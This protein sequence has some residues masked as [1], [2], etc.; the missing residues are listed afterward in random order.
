MA[1]A[2]NMPL[3]NEFA[4][5]PIVVFYSNPVSTN[6]LRLDKEH[7][8]V[9]EMLKR[10]GRPLE[11]VLRKHATTINDMLHTLK[12]QPFEIIL[13]SGHGD[14]AGILIEPE[15]GNSSVILEPDRLKNLIASSGRRPRAI[16]LLACYSADI[17]EDLLELSQFVITV[18]GPADDAAAIEF[19][20]A[21]MEDYLAH[22][23]IETAFG[24]AQKTIFAKGLTLSPLLSRHGQ[25]KGRAVYA[26][27]PGTFE[28]SILVDISDI[29][30]DIKNLG[31]SRDS[32]LRMLTQ[33]IRVH[34][35]LFKVAKE[36]AIIPIGTCFGVF[37]WTAPAEIVTCNRLL[38]V[39]EDAPLDA[40][41]AWTSALIAYNDLFVHRYRCVSGPVNP[42]GYT[43]ILERAVKAYYA[44]FKSYLADS[45]VNA[46]IFQ[47]LAPA[48]F[49]ITRGIFE[50]QLNRV[51]D[52]LANDD[53]GLVVVALETALT[54]LHDLISAVGKAVVK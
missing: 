16:V 38:S 10:I 12:G 48:Q 23:S 32:F 29:E 40:I 22:S 17:L 13:F 20:V 8:A 25:D 9:D 54:S 26:V 30:D 28:D 5:S 7:K 44:C 27:F 14:P 49:G 1:Y 4:K 51:D 47:K 52:S 24:T 43:K 45:S 36:E 39:K 18:I 3:V 21:L 6:R 35:W 11:T 37:S 15:S 33:K 2:F 42:P 50:G 31:L 19:A 34:H 53:H 41:T 46:T